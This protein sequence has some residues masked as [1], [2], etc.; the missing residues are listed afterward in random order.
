MN[1]QAR[2]LSSLQSL[3]TLMPLRA[4]ANLLGLLHGW[5]VA[6]TSESSSDRDLEITKL[7]DV[8][9]NSRLDFSPTMSVMSSP[10]VGL[11]SNL[12]APKL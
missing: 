3:R 11:K 1:K 2:A 6:Q 9:N 10:A 12:H 7:P 8:D 5:R 4:A